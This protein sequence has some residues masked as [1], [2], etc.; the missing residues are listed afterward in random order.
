MNK[1]NSFYCKISNIFLMNF[2]GVVVCNMQR[3]RRVGVTGRDWRSVDGA[4]RTYL[5]YHSSV[6][7]DIFV[8]SCAHSPKGLGSYTRIWDFPIP[9]FD[10]L[11][12]DY[13]EIKIL[14]GIKLKIFIYLCIYVYITLQQWWWLTIYTK[15]N[16]MLNLGRITNTFQWMR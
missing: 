14:L 9:P 3:F 4:A 11:L 12:K 15:I 13:S 2:W 16:Q 6:C 7:D 10:I 5:P 8:V 1:W